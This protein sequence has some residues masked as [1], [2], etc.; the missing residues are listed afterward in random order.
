VSKIVSICFKRVSVII[1]FYFFQGCNPVDNNDDP[2]KLLYSKNDSIKARGAYI[3]SEQGC[4][5]ASVAVPLLIRALSSPNVGL[6]CN[7][8]CALEK[9]GEEA[10]DAV[11]FLIIAL[12]DKDKRVRGNAAL[13]LGEIKSNLAL[14]IPAL[15]EFIKKNE[16]IGWQAVRALGRIGEKDDRVIPYLKSY[17]SHHDPRIGG[18]AIS[19]LRKIK[20]HA[21]DQ[22]D[23]E[24]TPIPHPPSPISRN[25]RQ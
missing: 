6:R 5:E 10:R 13:S 24:T 12:D 1:L 22:H 14:T 9:I 16:D 17:L 25:R 20:R 23:T 19:A 21:R 3:I 18:E 11:P 15:V 2:I 8:I 7:S 4:K